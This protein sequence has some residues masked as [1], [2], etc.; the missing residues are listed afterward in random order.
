MFF[1][2]EG[3]VENGAELAWVAPT[4]FYVQAIL[5][6]FDGDNDVAFGGGT[7]RDPLVTGRLRTFFEPTD[8]LAIQLAWISTEGSLPNSRA[9]DHP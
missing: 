3:L 6:I 9:S 7:L 5:G 2:D 8:T 4:P 1:G